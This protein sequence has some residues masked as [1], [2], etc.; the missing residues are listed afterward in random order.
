MRKDKVIIQSQLYMHEYIIALKLSAVPRLSVGRI[1][2]ES[3]NYYMVQFVHL[4]EPISCPLDSVEKID[5]SR[6]GKKKWTELNNGVCHDCG[7]A[8]SFFEF[9]ICDRCHILKRRTV[10][11]DWNQNDKWGRA[12]YRPSCKD[13]RKNIDGVNM[14]A[15]EKRKAELTRPSGIWSCPICEKTQMIEMMASKPRMDHDHATGK[16]R[17]WI[18]DSCNTGLGR[19]KDEIYILERAIE[20]LKGNYS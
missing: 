12:T 13:C 19:F 2:E 6:T 8:C 15:S 20:Y 4:P 10:Y 17:D 14:P 9:K 1:L 5:I 7:G 16:F 11:F 3:G 18:C